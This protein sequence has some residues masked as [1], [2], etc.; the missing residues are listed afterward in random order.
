MAHHG[1]DVERVDRIMGTMFV[2]LA[3]YVRVFRIGTIGFDDLEV[4]ATVP[5]GEDTLRAEAEHGGLLY[6]HVRKHNIGALLKS[7]ADGSIPVRV[8]RFHF[9]SSGLENLHNWPGWLPT[10]WRIVRT[11]VELGLPN[12]MIIQDRV[13]LPTHQRACRLE[14]AEMAVLMAHRGVQV[15]ADGAAWSRDLVPCGCRALTGPYRKD[16]LDMRFGRD[17]D[18]HRLGGGLLLSRLPET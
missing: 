11:R 5:W 7:G 12:D 3:E 13:I 16:G 6:P 9:G 17:T 8:P 4:L 15:L 2:S 10:G 1:T 14:T 18:E